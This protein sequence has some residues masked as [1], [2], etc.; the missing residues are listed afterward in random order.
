M[1]VKVLLSANL[2]DF[3][4]LKSVQTYTKIY[5]EREESARGNL[6]IFMHGWILDA[7]CS[8]L[9]TRYSMLDTRLYWSKELGIGPQNKKAGLKKLEITNYG[10][11]K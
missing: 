11:R 1:F 4:Y 8:M 2:K 3:F 7:R 9:D 5:K 6:K 10:L